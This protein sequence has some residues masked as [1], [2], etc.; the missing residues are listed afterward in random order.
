MTLSP[1]CEG[2]E[3]AGGDGLLPDV[4]VEVA[5]DLAL[6]EAALARLLEGA[7]QRHLAVRSL[8]RR[9]VPV[10]RHPVLASLC[11]PVFRVLVICRHDGP[12]PLRDTIRRT[13]YQNRDFGIR[14]LCP[15]VSHSTLSNHPRTARKARARWESV[16]LPSPISA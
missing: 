14:S 12:F 13:E 2:L 8:P 4:D 3:E 9:S 7:D 6:P 5:A 10:A 1:S 16:F 15:D 11:A